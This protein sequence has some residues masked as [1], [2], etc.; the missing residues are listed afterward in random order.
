MKDQ[1]LNNIS[2]FEIENFALNLSLEFGKDFE[3]K[4]NNRLELKF[5]K[6]TSE[7][8]ENYQT[9]CEEIKTECWNCIEPKSTKI[10]TAKLSEILNEK[11][12]E[13]YSWINERNKRRL[14]SQFSYYFWKDGILD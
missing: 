9:L 8:L 11:I 3:K 1:S 10:N 13:K 14:I 4:I 5:P 12:F 7:E 2:P 6:L